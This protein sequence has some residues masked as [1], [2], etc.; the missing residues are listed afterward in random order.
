MK[1][2]PNI[3]IIIILILAIILFDVYYQFE[4]KGNLWESEWL[5]NRIFILTAFFLVIVLYFSIKKVIKSKQ[6]QELFSKQLINSEERSRRSIASE[7]HDSLG[8]NLIMVN[9]KILQILS[10]DR[11]QAV[12]EELKELSNLVSDSI[13]EVRTISYNLYPHQIEKL[14]LT[15]ALKSV[16]NNIKHS[17]NMKFDYEVD[18]V[19]N[20]LSKEN[21]IN[22]F[23]IIQEAVNN[24]VRHSNAGEASVQIHKTPGLITAQVTDNG[25]GFDTK[26]ASN[27]LGLSNIYERTRFLKGTLKLDTGTNKGTSITLYIPI[28]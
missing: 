10:S 6:K 11:S 28:K 18:D 16:L 4:E 3:S 23:R 8:Q 12:R 21:E 19:D 2:P 22:F 20:V 17:T 24:V 14:G 13:E 26:Q 25:K 15:S 7:L 27:G 9:N 5:L 1:K